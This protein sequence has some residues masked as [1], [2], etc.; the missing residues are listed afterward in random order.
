MK[1][2]R[3]LSSFLCRQSVRSKVLPL[4]ILASSQS[5]LG[6]SEKSFTVAVYNIENLWDQIPQNEG[7]EAPYAQYAPK[8][9]NYY[10]KAAGGKYSFTEIKAQNLRQVALAI[11]DKGPEVFGIVEVESREALETVQKNVADL[12]YRYLA[13][14]DMSL[15]RGELAPSVGLGL[16]SKF[17][18]KESSYLL[19]PK[20][21]SFDTGEEND[22]F[23]AR[24]SNRRY[25][26]RPILKVTLDVDGHPLIVFLNHWKSKGGDGHELRRMAY[27]QVL[28]RELNSLGPKTDSLIMGDLNSNYDE[29][30]T[31]EERPENNTGE[32]KTGINHVLRT[33]GRE[34]AV[35]E[36]EAAANFPLY[37]LY[38]ELPQDERKSAYYKNFGGWASL[39]HLILS[40]GLYD[41]GGISYVDNSFKVA[42][43]N[44]KKLSFLFYEKGP[45]KGKPKRWISAYDKD[46]RKTVHQAGGYSD[47]LP[48]WAKF[49][50]STLQDA[51]EPIP[52]ELPSE[53]D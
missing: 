12:G 45:S 51:S 20:L 34:L 44:M 26:Q 23:F 53:E 8:T 48:I 10:E 5:L 47:H 2:A 19:V 27:A 25:L 31:I 43:P 17:P 13:F 16:L 29:F 4:L 1:S 49:Y 11:A 7:K 50:L 35:Q 32:G 42:A 39:D 41:Q 28:R 24:E 36:T 38:Y 3:Q 18:I 33:T 22:T 9:S 21:P 30:K 52:L 14:S 37:N 15:K 40:P 6:A 46:A